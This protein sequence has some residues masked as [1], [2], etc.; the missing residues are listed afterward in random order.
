[1]CET[2]RKV[3]CHCFKTLV[4]TGLYLLK[5]CIFQ[6]KWREAKKSPK[7][8]VQLKNVFFATKNSLELTIWTVPAGSE[9]LSESQ[10]ICARHFPTKDLKKTNIDHCIICSEGGSLICCDGCPYA[11]HEGCSKAPI[12]EIFNCDVSKNL[13]WMRI[14]SNAEVNKC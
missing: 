2:Q 7:T 11:F 13:N 12:G 14:H 5:Y 6:L 3:C 4:Y 8:N 9:L 10:L 1:M